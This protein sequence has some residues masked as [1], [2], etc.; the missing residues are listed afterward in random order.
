MGSEY[1][2][3]RKTALSAVVST[4]APVVAIVFMIESA[5]LMLSAT[6]TPPSAPTAA[7]TAVVPLQP[8]KG[9]FGLSYTMIGR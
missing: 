5:S 6:S 3:L 9:L 4:M 8:A 1:G 2:P 7:H